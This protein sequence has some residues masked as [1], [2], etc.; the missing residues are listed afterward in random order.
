MTINCELQRMSDEFTILG[1]LDSNERPHQDTGGSIVSK[2]TNPKEGMLSVFSASVQAA[3]RSA[4]G[5][6]TRTALDHIEAMANEIMRYANHQPTAIEF[7][8]IYSNR[9]EIFSHLLSDIEDTLSSGLPNFLETSTSSS[10]SLYSLS[11][12]EITERKALFETTTKKLTTVARKLTSKISE[13]ETL[14]LCASEKGLPPVKEHLYT[15]IEMILNPDPKFNI[16]TLNI[17][18]YHD[19]CAEI[20]KEILVESFGVEHVREVF[21][22]YQLDYAKRLKYA[23][24]QAVIIGIVAN[25]A[26]RDIEEIINKKGGIAYKVLQSRFSG[27]VPRILDE[28]NVLIILDILRTIDLGGAYCPKGRR[29]SE[30][31]CGDFL[32]L[33]SCK[34]FRYYD[35][36]KSDYPDA[37]VVNP[38]REFGRIEQ[39]ARE[40]AFALFRTDNHH[41]RAGILFPGYDENGNRTCFEGHN[42]YQNDGIYALASIPQPDIS[43]CHSLVNI[44]FRGTYQHEELPSAPS[45][46]KSS[47][48]W[49]WGSK[50]TTI[51]FEDT[52]QRIVDTFLG[53][54]E[55][56][57]SPENLKVEICGQGIGGCA[58][59]RFT[60]SLAN[61]FTRKRDYCQSPNIKEVNLYCFDSPTIEDP[62]IQRFLKDTLMLPDLQFTLRYFSSHIRKLTYY[63]GT[64][65]LGCVESESD[66]HPGNLN[67]TWVSL[68]FTNSKRNIVE[69]LADN[70]PPDSF[71]VERFYEPPKIWGNND[72]FFLERNK[73]EI[74]HANPVHF[75]YYCTTND[76]RKLIHKDVK[77]REVK[78]TSLPQVLTAGFTY[79]T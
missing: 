78:M 58:A 48:G 4:S 31:L 54:V 35:W 27:G 53:L 66:T 44:A 24:L 63:G 28:Q 70:Y 6:S 25:L 76:D 79:G 1:A 13:Y 64:H 17:N 37:S 3:Q 55:K 12:E 21:Q 61:T 5:N 34:K 71:A 11:N 26:Y 41:F 51:P 52:N 75:N 30:Q 46:E 59:Q 36:N 29:F 67:I 22:F 47:V 42:I 72:P 14:N 38:L 40:Y 32:F 2:Y 69:Q 43:Q 50:S 45:N 8:M 20:A 49:L 18:G 16:S 65:Y 7:Y 73:Y 77:G 23:D 10:S 9:I 74:A 62:I 56:I 39:F 57:T 15:I 60:E 19:F 68:G 33:E